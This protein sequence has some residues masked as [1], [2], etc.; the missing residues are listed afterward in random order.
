MRTAPLDPAAE[1]PRRKRRRGLWA[2]LGIIAIVLVAGAA[3]LVPQWQ[4]AT[5]PAPSATLD[6][7]QAAVRTVERY[8]DA[9]QQ[10]DC[11]E[12]EESTTP[13]FRELLLLPECSGFT[14]EAK[15]FADGSDDYH[16]EVVAVS[17]EGKKIIVSTTET[18][19]SLVDDSGAP[20]TA[21]QPM[22]RAYDYVV[23]A[24]ET[25]WAIDDANVS[26]P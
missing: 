15:S 12:Y 7:E 25:D 16:L 17:R 21:P 26:L 20:L 23:V 8:E 4:Q 13:A 5:S 1:Q 10:I 14:A 11:A 24:T 2:L 19:V 18:Y 9:W 22:T 3:V 6:P